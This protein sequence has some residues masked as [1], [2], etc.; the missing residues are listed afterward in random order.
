M[1]TIRQMFA[2]DA[3]DKKVMFSMC[4]FALYV[5]E[6]MS[7]RTNV[8]HEPIDTVQFLTSRLRS[9]VP[10]VEEKARTSPLLKAGEDSR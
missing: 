3:L 4:A 8:S 10:F 5:E 6:P 7:T 1:P 2:K 9:F